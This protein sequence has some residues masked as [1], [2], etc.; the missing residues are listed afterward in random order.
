MPV[1]KLLGA[2]MIAGAAPNTRP[3]TPAAPHGTAVPANG[4]EARRTAARAKGRSGRRRGLSRFARV[5][6]Q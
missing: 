2:T 3:L 5:A 6:N 4:E 1:S